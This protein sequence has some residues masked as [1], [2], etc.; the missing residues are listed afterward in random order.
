M[1]CECCSRLEPPQIITKTRKTDDTRMAKYCIGMWK[2]IENMKKTC[3]WQRYGRTVYDGSHQRIIRL[4]SLIWSRYYVK[5]MWKHGES[6][7]HGKRMVN[8]MVEGMGGQCMMGAISAAREG[9]GFPLAVMLGWGSWNDDHFGWNNDDHHCDQY[10]DDDDHDMV[11]TCLK[12]RNET[13]Y[14]G[15]ASH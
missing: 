5:S 8:D 13:T 2:Y 12:L 7:R 14:E 15:R 4:V 6:Q 10:E 1:C 3:G 9:E 11:K